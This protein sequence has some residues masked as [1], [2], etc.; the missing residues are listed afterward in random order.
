MIT[1]QEQINLVLLKQKY[2]KF[3]KNLKNS[4]AHQLTQEATITVEDCIFYGERTIQ[5]SRISIE[6]HTYL[7]LIFRL[8]LY[9]VERNFKAQ[10]VVCHTSEMFHR[11]MEH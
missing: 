5:F 3:K 1:V 6:E 2:Y 7:D 11:N 8:D 9:D 10:V 4:V